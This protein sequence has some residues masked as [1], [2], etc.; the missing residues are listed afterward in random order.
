M[1]NG[2][3]DLSPRGLVRVLSTVR[4]FVKPFVKPMSASGLGGR[5]LCERDEL[6]LPSP[7]RTNVSTDFST[8]PSRPRST[9]MFLLSSANP[10]SLRYVN[11]VSK[12][13]SRLPPTSAPEVWQVSY[14][15]GEVT[16]RGQNH[17]ILERSEDSVC[18]IGRGTSM[19]RRVSSGN[20]I[21]CLAWEEEEAADRLSLYCQCFD[22]TLGQS[23]RQMPYVRI[24]A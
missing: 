14:P 2:L 22:E 12:P 16:A 11:F 5:G 3:L 18:S 21:F 24:F 1:S 6:L 13:S 10:I 15:S 8:L 20:G 17:S 7:N 19:M 23:L 9:C 4:P